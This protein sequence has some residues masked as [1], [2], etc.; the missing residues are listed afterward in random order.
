[1]PAY[2]VSLDSF[3]YESATFTVSCHYKVNPIGFGE[4]SCSDFDEILRRLLGL[5]TCDHSDDD[6]V[7]GYTPVQELSPSRSRLQELLN[8]NRVARQHPFTSARQSAL[9]R[10]I[11]ICLR[12]EE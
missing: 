9:L 5:E 4:Y 10:L 8:R 12:D 3:F 2:S 1:M 11:G 7:F 6:L